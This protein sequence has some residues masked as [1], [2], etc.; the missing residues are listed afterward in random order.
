ML[1]FLDTEF[2]SL[3][4]SAQ[5]LSIGLISEADEHV[6]LYREV[7]GAA[8]SINDEFILSEIVPKLSGG[9]CAKSFPEVALDVWNW[10][11]KVAENEPVTLACDWSGDWAWAMLLLDV[12]HQQGALAALPT[13]VLGPPFLIWDTISSDEAQHYSEQWRLENKHPTHHALHDAANNR[14]TYL[15]FARLAALAHGEPNA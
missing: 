8:D 6:S 14:S 13:N 4:E 1:V 12:A 7:A 9:D 5:L 15:H 3:D 10:L 11:A 2:T